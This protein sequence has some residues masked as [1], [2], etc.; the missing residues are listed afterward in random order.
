VNLSKLRDKASVITNNLSTT[1]LIL[2]E[3]FNIMS[4]FKVG[5][6]VMIIK[7]SFK[8]EKAEI[9]E[10]S[11]GLYNLKVKLENNPNNY[12]DMAYHEEELEIIE[13]KPK[14]K[15]V[16]KYACVWHT[17]FES[18]PFTVGS[19]FYSEDE[20]K[21]FEKLHY[22]GEKTYHIIPTIFEDV[23]V[24]VETETRWTFMC[25]GYNYYKTVGK[26]ASLEKAKEVS[27]NEAFQK[28]DDSAEEF[29]IE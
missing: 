21:K 5:D 10:N 16:R 9:V 14:T 12:E 22:N 19:K 29:E 17:G 26:Y 13:Q 6:R 23:E 3:L 24:P 1:N 15:T 4:Q 18:K 27:N 7:G 20:L 8:G 25:K 28:I 2:Q 11:T